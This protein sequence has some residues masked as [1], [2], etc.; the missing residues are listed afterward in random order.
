MG[1][2]RVAMH[3]DAV[4][5]A[6]QGAGESGSLEVKGAVRDAVEALLS[7]REYRRWRI[8]GS[9]PVPWGAQHEW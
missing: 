4:P 2:G 6:L 7:P 8:S 3:L 5:M 9:A 1:R